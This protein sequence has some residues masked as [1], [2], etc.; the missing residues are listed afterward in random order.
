MRQRLKKHN[1]P[2]QN[3][4]DKL[5]EQPDL[6][7]ESESE[8]SASSDSDL[9]DDSDSDD[10][11]DAEDGV[12]IMNLKKKFPKSHKAWRVWS[13]PNTFLSNIST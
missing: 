5:R 2:Y 10:G 9:S 8:E 7:T 1:I 4:I 6:P 12:R 13:K 3:A 11:G